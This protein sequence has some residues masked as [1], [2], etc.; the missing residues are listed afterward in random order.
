MGD[1]TVLKALSSESRWHILR[2]LFVRPMS[3]DE[4]AEEAGLRPSTARHHLQPLIQIGLVEAY[5]GAKGSV[6]RPVVYYRVTEKRVDVSFPKRDYM[7]LSEIL[8]SGLKAYLGVEDTRKIFTWIGER[9][10]QDVM[11]KM[12]MERNIRTWT[13]EVFREI[14]IDSLLKNVGIEPEVL[15]MNDKEIVYR[16]SNCLFLE[17]AMKHPE[18]VCNGLDAGF[19]S[20]IIRCMGEEVKGERLQCKGHGDTHCVYAIKWG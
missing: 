11:K 12:A 19:H 7:D 9:A 10:G 3:I 5:E 13:P 15:T 2:S 18:T 6:G 17:T 4:I 8:V 16:E 1:V 14:F 20:G